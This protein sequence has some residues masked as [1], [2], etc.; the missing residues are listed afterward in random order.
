MNDMRNRGKIEREKDED[1]ILA[2]DII[3]VQHKNALLTSIERTALS[4]LVSH[5]HIYTHAYN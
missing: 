1:A 4:L 5:K 3:S 2:A